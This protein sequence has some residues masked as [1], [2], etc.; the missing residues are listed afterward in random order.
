MD[1]GWM[2]VACWLLSGVCYRVGLAIWLSRDCENNKSDGRRLLVEVRD[3]VPRNNE[4]RARL[5]LAQS[6][7]R[8][9]ECVVS[10]TME[11]HSSP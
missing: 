6:Y 5:S 9:K 4:L 7:F 3:L 1:A 10:L 11:L 8:P 2:L